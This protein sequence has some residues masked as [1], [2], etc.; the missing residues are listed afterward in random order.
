[1][2]YK[3][4]IEQKEGFI[5]IN[6]KILSEVSNEHIEAITAITVVLHN[7]GLDTYVC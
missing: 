2:I 6:S 3:K 4:N 7:S 1:M 5:V